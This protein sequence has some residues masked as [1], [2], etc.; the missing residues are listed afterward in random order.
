M[1]IRGI[2]NSFV[3]LWSHWSVQGL[4]EHGLDWKSIYVKKTNSDNTCLDGSN[5]PMYLF[6]C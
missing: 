5:G 3:R 1:K 6:H 4:F 2:V